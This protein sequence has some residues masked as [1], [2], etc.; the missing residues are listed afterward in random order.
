M[1][2]VIFNV[3]ETISFDSTTFALSNEP[4]SD[5]TGRSTRSAPDLKTD[6]HLDDPI[7]NPSHPRNNKASNSIPLDLANSIDTGTR[8]H[9]VSIPD[10]NTSTINIKENTH[11]NNEIILASITPSNPSFF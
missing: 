10:Q 9:I 8:T 3:V 7:I 5:A 2:L 4:S 6:H 1:Q 11:I